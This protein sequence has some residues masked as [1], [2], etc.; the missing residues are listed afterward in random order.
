MQSI[1]IS[2][3]KYLPHLLGVSILVAFL[4]PHT[5]AVM[6][7][8]NPLLC[9]LLVIANKE[10]TNYKE[11]YIVVIPILL[12]SLFLSNSTKE[13]TKTLFT[14]FLLAIWVALFVLVVF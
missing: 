2:E 3:N 13:Q 7:L 8:A 14:A 11:W 9:V 4:L 6:M 1:S 5:S 12:Y 10:R